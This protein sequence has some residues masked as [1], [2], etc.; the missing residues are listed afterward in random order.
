MRLEMMRLERCE[1]Y[2]AWG[3]RS[4]NEDGGGGVSRGWQHLTWTFQGSI[5]LLC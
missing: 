5:W 1:G 4:L 2:I 3:L